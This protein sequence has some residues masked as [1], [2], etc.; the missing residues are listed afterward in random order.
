MKDDMMQMIKERLLDELIDKMSVGDDRMKPKGVGVEVQAHDPEALKEGL[1]KAKDLVG[2][3]H[4]PEM[5]SMP[6]H[7]SDDDEGRML[8]LLAQDDDDDD[9]RKRF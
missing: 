9:D 5:E 4:A 2:S 8:E 3:A 1:D 7:G 6:E